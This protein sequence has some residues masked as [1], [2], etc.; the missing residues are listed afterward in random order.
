[1][2]DRGYRR[3]IPPLARAEPLDVAVIGAG[4]VGLSC[5]VWLLRAGHR[6]TLYDPGLPVASEAWCRAASF[7]N[8]CSFA[9]G[10]ILPIAA[11]GILRSVPRMVLDPQGPLTL[12]WRNLPGLVPWLA[13]FLRAARPEVYARGITALTALLGLAAASQEALMALSGTAGLRGGRGCLYLYRSAAAFAAAQPGLNRRRAAGVDVAVLDRAAIAEREPH[14]AP[15]YHAGA[16]LGDS[17]VLDDPRRYLSALETLVRQQ[18][19]LVAQP[20]RALAPEP[21]GLRLGLPEGSV[22]HRRVV[23]AAGAWSGGLART[24]GERVL[25]DTE[26]GYHVLFPGADGLLQG[27]VCY[28]EHGFFMSPLAEGLRCAGTVELGGLDTPPRWQRADT[29]ARVARTLLPALP[30]PGRKWMGSRPSTPDLLPVI[31]PSRIDPRV[32]H[33]YGHGHLGLTLGAV[34]GRVVAGLLSH[35]GGL[36]DLGPFRP[37]RFSRG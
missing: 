18:G 30:E 8:A 14:L 27:S 21:D 25:L 15:R 23:I 17:W 26:R 10:A 1:M 32:I 37:G 11:P 2:T 12:P 36:L 4:A 22:R 6:V 7:G 13:A 28:A 16:L 33:A 35:E 9:P 20:V 5:A 19:R 34:T 3:D 31:G 29:I 24:M